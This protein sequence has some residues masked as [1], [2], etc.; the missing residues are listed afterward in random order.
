MQLS[1][2]DLQGGGIALPELLWILVFA[3]AL[4]RA[5]HSLHH[6]ELRPPSSQPGLEDCK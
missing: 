4:E 3:A 1:C 6:G 2:H 5:V